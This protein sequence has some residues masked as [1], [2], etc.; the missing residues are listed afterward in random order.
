VVR[1]VHDRPTRSNEIFVLLATSRR[2]RS[3]PLELVTGV[4]ILPQRQTAQVPPSRRRVDTVLT[5][6]RLRRASASAGT[7]SSTR[8]GSREFANAGARSEEQ[9]ALMRASGRRAVTFEGR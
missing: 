9:I 7:R 4:V 6:R 2:S 3:G 1:A 8:A 5:R